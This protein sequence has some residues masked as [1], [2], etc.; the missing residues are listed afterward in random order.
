MK[1]YKGP[2]VL[3]SAKCINEYVFIALSS[4]VNVDATFSNAEVQRV[5]NARIYMLTD[6]TEIYSIQHNKISFIQFY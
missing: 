3:T 4:A 1:F 5:Q 2:V 6:V